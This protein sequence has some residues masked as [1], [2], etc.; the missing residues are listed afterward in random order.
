MILH[1]IPKRSGAFPNLLAVLTVIVLATISCGCCHALATPAPPRVFKHVFRHYDDISFDSWLRCTDPHDFLRSVGYTSQELQAMTKDDDKSL[2]DSNVH[3][4]WAPKIRFLVETLHGGTGTLT[5]ATTTTAGSRNEHDYNMDDDDPCVIRDSEGDDSSIYHTMR[6]FESTK[7]AVPALY[8][9][10]KQCPSLDRSVVPKHAYLVH[11]N[12]HPHS[13]ELLTWS[14][15]QQHSADDV[16]AASQQS[17][18]TTFLESCRSNHKFV[19]LC[20]Q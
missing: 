2:W 7:V 5:W 9:H 12:I 17:F 18:F 10:H 8:Y 3:S 11:H 4:H 1:L 19:E 15:Q 13:E 6:L 14:Q 20:N 16:A